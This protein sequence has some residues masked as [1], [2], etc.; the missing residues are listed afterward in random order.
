M[1]FEAFSAILEVLDKAIADN[2]AKVRV[3]A[4]DLSE[5]EI[6]SRLEKIGDRLKSSLTTA[7]IMVSLDLAK[8][9]RLRLSHSAGTTNVKAA[10][11]EP[12]AQQDHRS[13]WPQ[14]SNGSM[15]LNQFQLARV[16]CA[17]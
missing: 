6:V 9:K 16:F 13:R 14:G 1:G 10:Y 15:W 8:C 3:V 2:K 7:R 11:V 5:P 12:P 17:I 4:Y